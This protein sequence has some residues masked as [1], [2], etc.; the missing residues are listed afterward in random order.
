MKSNKTTLGK[1]QAVD[2]NGMHKSADKLLSKQ[3]KTPLG[4][5]RSVLDG[6]I[7]RVLED[8]IGDLST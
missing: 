8:W 1:T 5:Q 3:S 4:Q 2:G 6:H 7:P